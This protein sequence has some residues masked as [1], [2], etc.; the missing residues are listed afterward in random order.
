MHGIKVNELTTG[1]R[2]INAVSTSVIGLIATAPDA[3][4]EI[5]AKLTTGTIATNNAQ[6]FTAKRVGVAGNGISLALVN[7]V[8][9]SAALS[10]TVV[11]G[12]ITVSLATGAT[13]AIT[14]TA[15]QLAT[16]I[17]ANAAATALVAVANTGASTG[18][19]LVAPMA[20][21][22]LS[23]GVD[24]AF[25]LGARTLITDVRAAIA[26]AGSTGT[27]KATLEA[28]SD[29]CSPIIVLVR[30]AV[31]AVNQDSV[32]TAALALLVGAEGQL[33]V[34]PRI[35]GAPGLDTAPVAA[36]LA[37]TARKLRGMAYAMA[38]GGT[39]ALALTYRQNFGARELMLLWPGFAAGAVDTVARA[40]GLRARIDQEVGWH[41]TLSN[42]A[43]DGVT[44]LAADVT[45]DITADNH[46]AGVLNDAGIT[47]MIRHNGFRFWGNRT[48]SDEPLFAFESTVRTAQVLKDEIASGLM[49]AIDK[50]LTAMLVKDIVETINARGRALVGQQRL[51]GFNAWYDPAFNTAA[52][53]AAGKLVID[54]DFTA[55]APLES[56]TLNQRITDRYYA[57]FADLIG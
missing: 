40:L 5:K 35:L 18:A 46:D 57:N 47:T 10:I 4:G 14:T 39:R 27:L 31:D 1:T 17:A 24:E 15:A 3:Q 29:Q 44:G 6:T 12:A 55:V 38:Q 2:A 34:R 7:P 51:I 37:L 13:G 22:R 52:D 28:I 23:G 50:P 8:A 11:D 36:E 56:L 21:T 43:V 30:V 48:C 25:P 32:V 45:F 19:G 26:K 9:N 54:Y 42:I 33:G 20:A 41:K 16:A 49:W 53:L